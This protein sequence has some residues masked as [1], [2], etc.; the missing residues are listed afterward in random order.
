MEPLTGL[1]LAGGKST[2]F[3][4]DKASAVVAG[5]SMLQWVLEALAAVCSQL[6]VVRAKGQ[7]LPTVPAAAFR[8]VEDQYEAMGP[9]AGLVSGFPAVESELCFAAS[10]DVPLLRPELVSWLVARAERKDIVCPLVE[11]RLQPL[12]AVYRARACLPVFQDFVARGNLKVTAAFGPL[13]LDAVPEAEVRAIDPDLVSF[14]NANRPED[15]A[16][17]EGLLQAR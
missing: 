9:L 17:I 10:C 11:S 2:R 3:G 4:S 7:I 14:R 1:I 5:K 6:V 12:L 15:A 8:T 13:R 16:A